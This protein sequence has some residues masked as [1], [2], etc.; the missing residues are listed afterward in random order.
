MPPGHA[1]TLVEKEFFYLLQQFIA[2]QIAVAL[3][4]DIDLVHFHL[5]GNARP[6]VGELSGILKTSDNSDRD[7]NSNVKIGILA[8]E[9]AGI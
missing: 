9:G 2:S 5:A 1:H 3:D 7:V 4:L 6:F 8:S